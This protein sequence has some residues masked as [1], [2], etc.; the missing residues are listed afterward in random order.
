M[1]QFV[2]LRLIQANGLDL[3]LFQFDYDLTFSVFLMNADKTI[4]GRFGSR[5]DR[6]DAAKEITLEGFRKTLEGALE[7]HKKYPSNKSQLSGKKGAPPLFPVPEEFP[8]LR[9]KFTAQLT[10]DKPVASCI[11]CH[12]VREAQRRYYRSEKKPIDDEL[13]Y[14]WAMPDL[15]GLRL[16]PKERAWV[17]AVAPNSPAAAAGFKIG[18]DL[19]TLQ[20]Q[21]I[22]S[23]ADVQWVLHQAPSPAEITAVA[24]NGTTTRQLKLRLPAGWRRQTDISWRTSTWDLRR[25]TTGGLVLTDAD[26][27]Q[28]AKAGLKDS[29]LGLVVEYV[30]QYNEH[31]VGKKAGFKKDDI[32]LKLGEI[33]TKQTESQIMGRLLKTHFPGERVPALVL[34]GTNRVQLELLMQ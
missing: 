25:M 33:Q 7:L 30:G 19:L 29:D 24:R 21:P 28:R 16:D 32:I 26:S 2:C 4:Y 31:A 8:I 11:H 3:S 10:E 6:K 1:D 13:V 12:Q 22:I 15:I 9:G 27:A 23:V 14:P 20:N 34:Q 17:L 18:D 5:S